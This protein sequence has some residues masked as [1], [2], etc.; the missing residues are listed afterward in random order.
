MKDID[1]FFTADEEEGT[2]ALPNPIDYYFY[3]G[4]NEGV[5]TLNDDVDDS[6]V[7]RV[8]FPLQQL[9]MDPDI[10]HVTFYINSCGGDPQDGMAVVACLENMTTPV[11]ICILGR[12]ASAAGYIAMAKGP[13]I[14]TVCNKYSVSLLH[15]GSV[16]LSGNAN[17]AEDTHEFLKKYDEQ[18]LKKFVISHTKIDEEMYE[19]IKR[20]EYWMLADEM[21][22]LGIV[23]EIV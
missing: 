2:P 11:T 17:E 7:E 12:A 20:R 21:L 6:L 18:V 23:D 5:V 3:R 15:A 10:E 4:L 22:E 16:F 13:H 9:D 1:I 19:N 8:I 14:K